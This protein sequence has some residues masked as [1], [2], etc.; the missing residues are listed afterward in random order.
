M[1][2]IFVLLLTITTN[3]AFPCIHPILTRSSSLYLYSASAG[4]DPIPIPF[5]PGLAIKR[6]SLSPKSESSL[7]PCSTPT[8]IDT[9]I[10][11]TVWTH[12]A[13]L[14]PK[15]P[16]TPLI[17][18]GQGFPSSPPPQFARDALVAAASSTSS[19]HQYTASSGHFPL[20]KI[21]AN[22]YSVHFSRPLD[23]PLVPKDNV[24]VSV[25]ASQ[26]LYIAL[27]TL[28]NP[29][30]EVILFQP[31]FDLY[32]NQIK[33]AGGTPV[34]CDALKFDETSNSWNFDAKTFDTSISPRTKVVILNSPHNPTGKVFSRLEM[35]Q[36]ATSIAAHE[37][38]RVTVLSD[39]VY[40]FIV[41]S[42]QGDGDG[43]GDG[44]GDGGH[45]HFATIPNMA[46]RTITIS[47]AGKTF[48]ATGWQVGWAVGPAHLI[49]NMQA[50][51]PYV[52]FCASTVMQ[53]AVGKAI[54]EA[55]KNNYYDQLNSEVSEVN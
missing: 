48:S 23:R 37:V 22:R 28:L 21:L 6:L 38:Q 31:F 4:A 43:E 53:E 36:I 50:L 14:S 51:M 12:F 25:G 18:L 44:E 39:E 17:N 10:P 29:G 16:G 8:P 42:K 40:K 30:D 19:L 7:P 11:P 3:K 32:V 34:F 15:L 35:S 46:D 45:I 26:A 5:S 52:Q 55:A 24:C 41:H 1:H 2:F 54:E 49:K 33:L 13:S 9:S 20:T 47:S 27:Q